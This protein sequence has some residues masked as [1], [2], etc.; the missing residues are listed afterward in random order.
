MADTSTC[1]RYGD[2]LTFQLES[3]IDVDSETLYIEDSM[4]LS[5]QARDLTS[6]H[7]YR[8]KVTSRSAH[9]TT[10]TSKVFMGAIFRIAASV[11][12]E[13]A[14]QAV[15][16]GSS[17]KLIFCRGDCYLSSNRKMSKVAIVTKN[18]FKRGKEKDFSFTVKPK[19]SVRADGEI[20]SYE[21]IIF[22][23]DSF[24]RFISTKGNNDIVLEEDIIT[25]C[26]LKMI[27]FVSFKH[28][29]KNFLLGG[30]FISLFHQEKSCYLT[31]QQNKNSLIPV[32]FT[33][34]SILPPFSQAIWQIEIH[35]DKGILSNK[36]SDYLGLL[37]TES[38]IRLRHVVT[39][40][41]LGSDED[42]TFKTHEKYEAKLFSIPNDCCDFEI[43]SQQTN[44]SGYLESPSRVKFQHR[45]S[46]KLLSV[47]STTITDMMYTFTNKHKNFTDVYLLSSVPPFEVNDIIFAK[48]IFDELSNCYARAK[49]LDSVETVS[50]EKLHL[51]SNSLSTAQQ[52]LL[53]CISFLDNKSTPNDSTSN[54][55]IQL[56]RKQNIILDIGMVKL[57]LNLIEISMKPLFIQVNN[58]ALTKC[59]YQALENVVRGNTAVAEYIVQQGEHGLGMHMMLSHIEHGDKHM[60]NHCLTE[61]T[62]AFNLSPT[63]T[64]AVI[65]DGEIEHLINVFF[66]KLASSSNDHEKKSF[67]SILTTFSLLIEICGGIFEDAM[68]ERIQQIN[69]RTKIIISKK[70]FGSFHH[71]EK[72]HPSESLFLFRHVYTKEGKMSLITNLLGQVCHPHSNF[73]DNAP[74]RQRVR[75]LDCGKEF[76]CLFRGFDKTVLPS[77]IK[78]CDT[79]VL[80]IHHALR[81]IEHQ[82]FDQEL[83]FNYLKALCQEETGGGTDEEEKL[84]TLKNHVFMFF[85]SHVIPLSRIS[86]VSMEFHC[87]SLKL[88]ACLCSGR[89]IV[90]QR[91]VRL[92]L[93]VDTLLNAIEQ[94][95]TSS[96]SSLFQLKGAYTTVLS[97]CYIDSAYLPS[98]P[99]NTKEFILHTK[100]RSSLVHNDWDSAY[101]E[102]CKNKVFSLVTQENEDFSWIPDN[103]SDEEIIKK[104]E[105]SNGSNN[106]GDLNDG[107]FFQTQKSVSNSEG[108]NSVADLLT[109]PSSLSNKKL[110]R[111][112][113]VDFYKH[114][115]VKKNFKSIRQR[116]KLVHLIDTGF[117][118]IELNL[119]NIYLQQIRK[120]NHSITE[121]EEHKA[122]SFELDGNSGKDL[123]F[124]IASF[125]RLVRCLLLRRFFDADYNTDP[126]YREETKK[127]DVQIY[128]YESIL[129]RMSVRFARPS[130]LID[131]NYTHCSVLSNKNVSLSYDSIL[132]TLLKIAE[133]LDMIDFSPIDR[134]A[135][136]DDGAVSCMKRYGY[137]SITNP[138]SDVIN[139]LKYSCLTISTC[140]DLMLFNDVE[141][142]ETFSLLDRSAWTD[143]SKAKTDFSKFTPK[144]KNNCLADM[145]FKIQVSR[146]FPNNFLNLWKIETYFSKFSLSVLNFVYYNDFGLREEAL[147]LISKVAFSLPSDF[148]NI[149][150]GA[151]FNITSGVLDW[152]EFFA[153]KK[154]SLDKA[155]QNNKFASNS[156]YAICTDEKIIS[157]DMSSSLIY[158]LKISFSQLVNVF[159]NP[160]KTGLI[161]FCCL[162]KTTS[163][164]NPDKLDSRPTPA[165]LI[166]ISYNKQNYRTSVNVLYQSILREIGI[167]TMILNFMKYTYYENFDNV[168]E[169]FLNSYKMNTSQSSLQQKELDDL[170][171]IHREGLQCTVSFLQIFI[172]NNLENAAL[173]VRKDIMALLIKTTTLSHECFRLLDVLL[174]IRPDSASFIG[175]TELTS[176]TDNCKH[177]LLDLQN[178]KSN[179]HQY[180]VKTLC[181]IFNLLSRISQIDSFHLNS[182]ELF[183]VF[184]SITEKGFV[185][186]IIKF[187]FLSKGG[188]VDYDIADLCSRYEIATG[189]YTTSFDY[190]TWN[191]EELDKIDHF[192]PC[193]SSWK[194]LPTDN[195]MNV[196]FACIN[197]LYCLIE[198]GNSNYFLQILSNIQLS[199]SREFILRCIL[200]DKH[201]I[202]RPILKLACI[203]LKNGY[204]DW[205]FSEEYLSLAAGI[206][207]SFVQDISIFSCLIMSWDD[208]EVFQLNQ[209]GKDNKWLI[210]DYVLNCV[211]PFLL[212]FP[213]EQFLSLICN[214]QNTDQDQE[215]TFS[216]YFDYIE[217]RLDEL[218]CHYVVKTNNPLLEVISKFLNDFSDVNTNNSQ[219]RMN[220]IT[221][222]KLLTQSQ[223][224]D[225]FSNHHENMKRYSTEY[226]IYLSIAV[227][228]FKEFTLTNYKESSSKHSS[229]YAS[230]SSISPFNK[231]LSVHPESF[232]E[233]NNYAMNIIHSIV[234][235]FI[236]MTIINFGMNNKMMTCPEEILKWYEDKKN[237]TPSSSVQDNNIIEYKNDPKSWFKGESLLIQM[238]YQHI[239]DILKSNSSIVEASADAGNHLSYWL[240]V[241][242]SILKK[243]DTTNDGEGDISFLQVSLIPIGACDVVVEIISDISR[244]L[245]FPDDQSCMHPIC[246]SAFK[247]GISLLES[248]NHDVQNEFI[249]IL[250]RKAENSTL[251]SNSQCL[252]SIRA[253]LRS[254]LFKINRYSENS[255]SG[256]QHSQMGMQTVMDEVIMVMR[257]LNLMCEG[258][259][260]LAQSFLQNQSFINSVN[261]VWETTAFAGE[262]LHLMCEQIDAICLQSN[263]S[264]KSLFS[265]TVLSYSRKTIDWS[266][267]SKPTIT[268]LNILST[269]LQATFEVLSEMM[270]GPHEENQKCIAKSGILHQMSDIF[271]F[272]GALQL[273]TKFPLHKDAT[274]IS[275]LSCYISSDYNMYDITPGNIKWIGRDPF[276]VEV[277]S[278]FGNQPNK[279]DSSV[280]EFES[281]ADRTEYRAYLSS[282]NRKGSKIQGDSIALSDSNVYK[283]SQ[284]TCH[285]FGILETSALKLIASM[286]EGT[287]IEKNEQI[288]RFVVDG[289]TKENFICNMVNYWERFLD[290]IDLRESGGSMFSKE[291]IHYSCEFQRAFD[292]YSIC[293]KICDLN[294]PFVSSMRNEIKKWI[295]DEIIPIS[296]HIARIEVV[297][298]RGKSPFTIYF[299]IPQLIREYW[300]K[301]EMIRRRQK[302][303]YPSNADCRSSIEEKVNAFIVDGNKLIRLLKQFQTFERSL[304]KWLKPTFEI[305]TNMNLWSQLTLVMTL[306]I[307]GI[308]LYTNVVKSLDEEGSQDTIMNY[309]E[310]TKLFLLLRIFHM[311]SFVILFIVYCIIYGYFNVVVGFE[312]NKNNLI[313]VTNIKLQLIITQFIKP[314][315][316]EEN[317]NMKFSL[318]FFVIG[319]IYYFSCAMSV[320]YMSLI[321]ISLLGLT[322]SP[323]WYSLS[324]IDAMRISNDMLYVAQSFT[325]NL[326]QLSATIALAIVMI[327]LFVVVSFVSADLHDQYVVGGNSG[328]AGCGTLL[329]CFRLHFDYGFMGGINFYDYGNINSTVG[330]LYNFIFVFVVQIIFPGIVSGI[331]IDTFASRR[332]MDTVMADDVVNTCFIC[333][334]T[335]E[336]FETSNV[337]F[338]T[339]IKEEHNMWQYIW[340]FIYLQERDATEFTGIE[341]VCFD[342]IQS[343]EAIHFLPL[344]VA[345]SLLLSSSLAEKID[346]Y[347]V[348]DKLS[349][350]AHFVD[351][352]DHTSAD[353]LTRQDKCN[354]NVKS[355][356]YKE[357]IIENEDIFLETPKMKS[358]TLRKTGQTVRNLTTAVSGFSS[359]IKPKQINK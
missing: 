300:L 205:A 52:L 12:Y 146:F 108:N 287:I 176:L 118:Q 306:A 103:V 99:I 331:I 117:C 210:V 295:D 15:R 119:Q 48:M 59:A 77:N 17:I 22:L 236:K 307:N 129:L 225:S 23:K 97:N 328:H 13:S 148:T 178:G 303:V 127:K 265:P 94:C 256:E 166:M 16:Y 276:I 218:C 24:G 28:S 349:D 304:G 179:S 172:Q 109:T 302:I 314:F 348:S 114:H 247:L 335:R 70:I 289:I 310:K 202:R 186:E 199:I 151:L 138:I 301:S 80:G 324:L 355:L 122:E 255:K 47:S 284:D 168:A 91:L 78:T 275:F 62:R 67:S 253:L 95:N 198:N 259:N 39:G 283:L 215:E 84:Q 243:C 336:D 333:N 31:C 130:F 73:L 158:D 358:R 201:E 46:G 263:Q 132:F 42:E 239:I 267:K 212:L 189:R 169:L 268:C 244:I 353:F 125:I 142:L 248:G 61:I 344:R 115:N 334:I 149:L 55:L 68:D 237:K 321:V 19:Y 49:L 60:G 9:E 200:I 50:E 293:M 223:N 96:Q 30:D 64:Q 319:P 184:N 56:K 234:T 79:F 144:Q 219:H 162:E 338:S 128:F 297:P 261:I 231:H 123:L 141:L 92:I 317:G 337:S 93:P 159:S 211:F 139:V 252:R 194:L 262:I 112:R 185:I 250:S 182:D 27:P 36:R 173:L 322:M 280:L 266:R 90:I 35:D 224:V 81:N 325:D 76:G 222:L 269:I 238:V 163:E 86:K 278:K 258:H 98:L 51:T 7:S 228:D 65:T 305:C 340:Y 110:N 351:K 177:C 233:S 226:A 221:S 37:K 260:E 192:I 145:K 308:M 207:C 20:V 101:D 57:F 69:T 343:G 273:E 240:D 217:T 195:I 216:G 4:N 230:S 191:S 232:T 29:D 133:K 170:I 354:E 196:S 21:D 11:G 245:V 311:L 137:T 53:I 40:V 85:K 206:L 74:K 350:L 83:V 264:T 203:L 341:Q 342:K 327:Y 155:I 82:N 126:K 164:T 249:K 288:P 121:E 251:H 270:Q 45:N 167:H 71:T 6:Y 180:S 124:W 290:L 213:K 316:N 100:C 254:Y 116:H 150:A 26:S 5:T 131:A 315:E 197:W 274:F 241:S 330:E 296:D 357:K 157:D 104:L 107:D 160:S 227:N 346:V 140:I 1:L 175:L 174:T 135:L 54:V 58:F 246:M 347:T 181:E 193:V 272:F 320:Y 183:N 326:R 332:D 72:F 208:D 113:L 8:M 286:L 190:T 281:N 356:F 313:N 318:P 299:P 292:Y 345:R 282:R 312:E 235:D 63:R 147:K 66:T 298:V 10:S 161:D 32:P 136:F 339:H 171:E 294:F 156:L 134:I 38:A 143:K 329:S 277:L 242:T 25:R 279:I 105:K 87:L 309:T 352:V 152:Q 220:G 18:E 3:A 204:F 359:A 44:S 271:S 102:E 111:Q 154:V 323:L 2:L 14:G 43:L 209:I 88:L 214:G 187:G 41:Y 285:Q 33:S 188:N 106:Y 75:F 34:K 120:Q 291:D 165:N 257:F 89:N 153:S 229:R